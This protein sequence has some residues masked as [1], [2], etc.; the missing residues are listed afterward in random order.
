LSATSVGYTPG[1]NLVAEQ[2]M[3]L[4]IGISLA[5]VLSCLYVI[6]GQEGLKPGTVNAKDVL[7]QIDVVLSS[8]ELK[9]SAPAVTLRIVKEVTHLNQLQIDLV[10]HRASAAS[11]PK[12]ISAAFLPG[13]EKAFKDLRESVCRDQPGMVVNGDGKLEFCGG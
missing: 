8:G 2:K 12:S 5:L 7:T 1:K 11:D 6:D 9:E 4:K 13:T 3:R 10:W